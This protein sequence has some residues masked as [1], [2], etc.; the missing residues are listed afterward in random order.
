M[1]PETDRSDRA[2]GDFP[3]NT[4]S[5]SISLLWLSE[6]D[7]GSPPAFPDAHMLWNKSSRMG[8]EVLYQC[9]YG[10]QNVGKGNVSICTAAGQ[11]ERPYVLCQGTVRAF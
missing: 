11:W 2:P 1:D 9:V 8:T 4:V 3:V 6:I 10:Y 5:C 7:C